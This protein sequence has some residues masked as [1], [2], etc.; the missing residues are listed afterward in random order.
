M[1]LGFKDGYLTS[2]FGRRLGL[3]ALSSGQTGGKKMEFLV[4]PD[5]LRQELVTETTG[6]NLSAAGVSYLTTG[7]ATTTNGFFVI[8][9]PVPGVRKTIVWGSTNTATNGLAL[10]ASTGTQFV[11]S[12]TSAAQLTSSSNWPGIIEL[13]GITTAKWYCESISTLQINCTATT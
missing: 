1:A 9:P 8:D 10:W 4:N 5:A 7:G 6:I 2:L 3:Q 13:I 12:A 11:T